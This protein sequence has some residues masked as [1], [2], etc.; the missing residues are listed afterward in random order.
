[1]ASSDSAADEC[2]TVANGVDDGVDDAE[3]GDA[4]ADADDWREADGAISVES[5]QAVEASAAAFLAPTPT[6]TPAA[7]LRHSTNGAMHPVSCNNWVPTSQ[8][9]IKF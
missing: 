8:T 3:D 5:L 4:E 6:L 2:A 1:V 9:Q 7:C